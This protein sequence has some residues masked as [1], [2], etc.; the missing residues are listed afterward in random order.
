MEEFR[1]RL[2]DLIAEKGP[3]QKEFANKIGYNEQNL[4]NILTGKTRVPRID[5]LIAILNRFPEV[6]MNHMLSGKATT[7]ISIKQY[8]D[9]VSDIREL[10]QEVERL[11]E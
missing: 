3:S 2:A 6:D 1:K 8:E 5:I 11:K 4:S 9:L 10:Q 7:N